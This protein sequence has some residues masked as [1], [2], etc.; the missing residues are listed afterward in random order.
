MAT[1]IL[2]APHADAASASSFGTSSAH[3]MARHAA[4]TA[5]AQVDLLDRIFMLLQAF[6][7]AV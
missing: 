6:M 3:S 1:E 7:A 2:F 5:A 4:V